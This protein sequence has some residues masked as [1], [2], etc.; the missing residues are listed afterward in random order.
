MQILNEPTAA[1][2]AYTHQI[3]DDVRKNIL[4]YDLGGGTF[5][6]AI[7]VIDKGDIDV[8]AV[9][10]DTHLGG[11]DFDQRIMNHFYRKYEDDF[12]KISN[13]DELRR[14]MARL[15]IYCEKK[16]CTISQASS[17]N[18]SIDFLLPGWDF[19]EVIKQSS[20]ENICMDLFKKTITIVDETLKSAKINKSDID[21]IVLI[22]GSAK[23]PKIQSLLREYFDGKPLNKKIKPDEAVAYGATI[24]A[25]LLNGEK[26]DNAI[27]FA[28]QDVSSFSLGI[29]VLDKSM[30]VII[31]KNSKLPVQKSQ[32]FY[33]AE[34]DQT[35]VHIRI[36]E[37][38]NMRTAI[39]NRLL[40]QFIIIDLP[41]KPAGQE[42]VD[43]TF[44]IDKEGILHVK[45]V[46][47]EKK[48]T[49]TIKGQRGR[50]SPEE[51]EVL[52]SQVCY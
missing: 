7:V 25:A 29:E 19:N 48:T 21:E 11:V 17:A 42:Y 51:L 36:F 45:G 32:R 46:T 18:I 6:V 30:A 1:A 14:A 27:P 40:G 4:I 52:K 33:T 34:N 47:T 49:F 23:I 20:F 41:K 22:G 37:G 44:R 28:T 16:K 8:R 38:E 50:I 35:F 43:V 39:L 5:D 13:Q 9:G 3:K 10:G 15:K 26:F 24:Q 2:I 31:P 12:R